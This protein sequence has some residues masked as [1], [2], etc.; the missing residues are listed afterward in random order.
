MFEFVLGRASDILG[1]GISKDWWSFSNHVSAARAKW[2]GCGV[3]RGETH[4]M[5][6]DFFK[7]SDCL[8]IAL[9]NTDCICG[10]MNWVWMGGNPSYSISLESTL[11]TNRAEGDQ[12]A[13]WRRTMMKILFQYIVIRQACYHHNVWS[14]QLRSSS[15]QTTNEASVDGQMHLLSK[16][17]HLAHS[18]PPPFQSTY[19]ASAP[20]PTLP[21]CVRDSSVN[22]M[23]SF[24]RWH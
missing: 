19:F 15:S 11:Q 9:T 16:R 23:C 5:I 8:D 7:D 2:S 1:N 21:I 10:L 4:G 14:K 18:L 12:G 13:E 22:C 6:Q 3:R 17:T 24:P 20:Y